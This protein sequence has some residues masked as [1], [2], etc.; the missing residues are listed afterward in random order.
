MNKEKVS[1]NKSLERGHIA[2]V[3]FGDFNG[4]VQGGVRPCVIISNNRANHFSPVVICVPLTSKVGKKS[5]PTHTLIQPC[6]EDNCLKR[7]SVA[8]CEQ[9]ITITKDSI[10]GITGKLSCNDCERIN[11]CVKISLAL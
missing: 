8:L 1:S 4:S 11:E 3:D 9:I 5:L 6:E 2:M 10:K 7:A